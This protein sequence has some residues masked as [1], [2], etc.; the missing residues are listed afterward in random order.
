M[1]KVI[2]WLST[3][4]NFLEG[5]SG[6]ITAVATALIA[7]FTVALAYST[8]RLWKATKETAEAALKTAEAL[9]TVERAYLFVNKV[10]DAPE[11]GTDKQQVQ[12]WLRNAGKTPATIRRI[13]EDF[14]QITDAPDTID[15][16]KCRC[17]QKTVTIPADSLPKIESITYK[18]PFIDWRGSFYENN[19]HG[20]R[21]VFYGL[22]EY[23]DVFNKTHTIRF[24]WFQE[25]SNTFRQCDKREHNQECDGPI[26]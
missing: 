20:V 23:D 2:C 6:A 4:S 19:P 7:V 3:I 22:I 9:P 10:T 8:K 17:H 14:D 11:E 26:P 18:L 16:S 21:W 13:Y 1:G 5:H 15:T 25:S 12:I 24:C